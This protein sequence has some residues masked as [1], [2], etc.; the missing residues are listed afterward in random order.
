MPLSGVGS[1]FFEVGCRTKVLLTYRWSPDG[2]SLTYVLSDD[3][4]AGTFHWHLATGAGDREI[5]TA[6]LW[7]RDT[8]MTTP[9][10]SQRFEDG[11]MQVGFSSDGKLVWLVERLH[12]STDLQVRSL[13]GSLVGTEIRG[14][15]TYLN[16]V[17]MG[18]WSGGE[19]FYRDSQGVSRWADGVSKRFLPGVG[20]LYPK[21]SPAGGQIV[22]VVRGSDGLG[23]INVV[24]TSNGRARQLTNQP[25]TR[26]VFLTPR[27]VWYMGERLCEP[28]QPC[29]ASLA[30]TF[31]GTTYIYDLQTGTESESVI[32]DVADVWPHGA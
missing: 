19:L 3:D 2:Q 14:D 1:S 16:P 10:C 8:E 4:R 28:Q 24:D 17:S 32:T 30:S 7:C 27:Y 23:R 20:W 21:A 13:D 5:G 6:P 31:T 12:N 29:T 25:R 22:Y 9:R 26:P 11:G 18:L 15:S